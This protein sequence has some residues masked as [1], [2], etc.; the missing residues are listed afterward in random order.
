MVAYVRDPQ[1]A[2]VV[3]ASVQ[4]QV[5]KPDGQLV[6]V[7]VTYDPTM[8][9]YVGRPTGIVPGSYP[10]QVQVQPPGTAAPVQIETPPVTVSAVTPVPRAR[11]G[12]Q[13]QIVGDHAVEM[14]ATPSGD[15]A[16]FWMNLDGTPIP[17]N[18]VQVPNVTVTVNGRPHVVP[19][20]V[21]SD[22]IVAHVP[23]APHAP[24]SV[25]VPSV[26]VQGV[27]Y[28]TV[29]AP[30][31]PV[32]AVL[33]PP[34]PV[35]V[36]PPIVQAGFA[37]PPPSVVV[38]APVPPAI[39]VGVPA[40]PAVVVAPP[41]APAVVVAPPRPGVII[42]PPVPPAVVVAPPIAPAVVVAPPVPGVAVEVGHEP[43][44]HAYGYWR[45]HGAVE[46]GV[47]VPAPVVVAPNVYV[48]GPRPGVWVGGGRGHGDDNDQGE[49]H[50]GGGWH[51]H[52]HEH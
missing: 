9:A 20:R 32:V 47:G 16:M 5:R 31:T 38:G 7:P 12:G 21:E 27:P 11:Y 28:T 15:M 36:Q 39:V 8:Q 3:G 52:G 35:I 10:V 18:Q 48:A 25:S 6:P 33:P 45:N 23:Y 26:T 13:V 17:A 44:G 49:H 43:H 41:V 22:R 51:G 1:R 50:G 46:V 40:P 14:V 2:P 29:V 30:A 34:Q 37:P 24:V 42:A 19:A 4:L